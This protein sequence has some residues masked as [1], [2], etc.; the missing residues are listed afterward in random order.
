[1]PPTQDVPAQSNTAAATS[2]PPADPPKTKNNLY[3]EIKIGI[4]E[5][6]NRFY[7]FPLIGFLT[8]VI[9]LIPVF[10]WVAILGFV[11][12]I[13]LIINSFSVLFTGKYWKTAYEFSLGLMRLSIKVS[14][15]MQG[16]TDKY[17]GFSRSIDQ[18]NFSV[19]LAFPESPNKLYAI[20]IIGGL[21]RIILLIPYFIY[22]AVIS[23]A[24][25][26]GVFVSFFPV[27][28]MGKYPESTYEL[29]RDSI[30]VSQA[31][32][33]YMSGLSD[34]YP[35]FYISMNHKTVKIILIV[36]GAL[37]MLLN[38]G[39]AR[40]QPSNVITP[41]SFNTSSVNTTVPGY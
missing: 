39:N 17:P 34:K 16:L 36:L 40:R 6:P 1:M 18:D 25:N 2:D 20:P 30:R 23:Y 37:I 28:F 15:F 29:A 7:A 12:G 8:K 38:L 9:I 33:A 21:I 10:I 41:P 27:L 5:K 19:D 4:N 13:L 26:I 32:T 14:Y 35:S 22:Q 31:V 11:Q 24:A 3:P